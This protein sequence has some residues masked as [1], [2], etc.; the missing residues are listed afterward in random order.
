M[1]GVDAC[2]AGVRKTG[3]VG[4]VEPIGGEVGMQGV[5]AVLAT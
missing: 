3:E 1:V 4:A 2:R 5:V